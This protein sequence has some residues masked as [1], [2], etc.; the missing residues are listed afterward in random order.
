MVTNLSPEQQIYNFFG[1]NKAFFAE[2]NGPR[3]AKK[4]PFDFQQSKNQRAEYKLLV[5]R[6][7]IR[8]TFF[9]RKFNSIS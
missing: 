7:I 8:P 6:F 4:Q 5:Y 2:L 1:K 9:F 3:I